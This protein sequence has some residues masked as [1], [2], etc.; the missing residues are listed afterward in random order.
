MHNVLI[1]NAKLT[2]LFI[3]SVL[4]IFFKQNSAAQETDPISDA[5]NKEQQELEGINL[6]GNE[7]QDLDKINSKYEISDKQKKA[8]MDRESGQKLHLSDK[9]QLGRA[10]RKDYMRK[11]KIEKFNH[12]VIYNRQNEATKQ[13]MHENDKKIKK[14]D[15]EIKRKQRR[16]K[17]ANLFK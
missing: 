3:I 16:K 17:F 8:R 7:K 4:F 12:D 13:R 10:N 15:K 9:Y 2:K 1:N 14:R 6:F 11:K 5:V